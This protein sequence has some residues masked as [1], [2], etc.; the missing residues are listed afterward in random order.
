MS[1]SNAEAPT[2]EPGE[3]LTEEHRI[4]P[5]PLYRKIR[6]WEPVYHDRLQ[7]RFFVSRY[8]D[9]WDAYKRSRD[10]G[11]FTRAIYEPQGNFEFGSESPL[12][13]TILEMG[14]G[15]EHRWSRGIVAGEFVGR[16]LTAWLPIIERTAAEMVGRFSAEAAEGLAGDLSEAG[17]ID[18][19]SQ[20]SR[21][22]PIRVI[23][24][25]LGLPREDFDYFEGVYSTLFAGM[26]Y[27]RAYFR[28]GVNARNELHDYLDPIIADRRVNPTGDLISKLCAAE[29]SGKRMSTDEIKAFITLLLVGGGDTTHKAID[30]MWWHLLNNY[31]QYEAVR[32]NPD[33]LERVFTEM[34]RYDGPNHFQPRRTTCETELGGRVLPKGATVALCLGSANRDERVFN[35][36]DSFNIFRDDLYFGKELRTGYWQDGVASH[37]G[38]GQERH[39]C[40]GYAM[41]RQEAVTASPMLLQV[42]KN[43]RL[44]DVPNHGIVFPHRAG[45]ACGACSTS[46]SSSTRSVG[47]VGSVAAKKKTSV[48]PE[49]LALYQRLLEAVEGVEEKSNFGSAYTAVNG[50]M[51]SM[52]SKYGVVGIR[53]PAEEREAFLDRYDTE[54]FRGDPAWPVSKEYVAVPDAMLE[55]TGAL[56]PYLELSLKHALTLKPKPTKRATK[57]KAAAKK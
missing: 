57:K 50:N 47:E 21:R 22:F 53:L 37:L 5:F 48:P 33:L 16:K 20:F 3:F 31:D 40:L 28:T 4:D 30:S 15:K 17:E 8:A 45:V 43:P 19:V 44:K 55:D 9:I 52:I 54:L 14:E 13:S 24:G 7:N 1:T 2:I 38:F 6:D 36:P 25:M 51:Y 12:R 56:V 11:D 35:D 49:K 34:L 39:F 41:A 10:G 29:M 42:L 32:A 18:L 46:R 26:G 23:A 27:G